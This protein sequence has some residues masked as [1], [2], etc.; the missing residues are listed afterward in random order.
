MQSA[1]SQCGQIKHDNVENCLRRCETNTSDGPREIMVSFVAVVGIVAS[2]YFIYIYGLRMKGGGFTCT[3]PHAIGIEML[4]MW[5]IALEPG[6]VY[7]L[8][9]LSQNDVFFFSFYIDFMVIVDILL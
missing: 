5:P 6:T 3:L 9:H 7:K 1:S 2:F 8:M 4:Q